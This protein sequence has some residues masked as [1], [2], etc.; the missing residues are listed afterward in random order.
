MAPPR[1]R[2]TNDRSTGVVVIWF[3]WCT[4]PVVCWGREG[5]TLA[6]AVEA[7]ASTAMPTKKKAAQGETSAARRDGARQGDCQRSKQESPADFRRTIHRQEPWSTV[8]ATVR[9]HLVLSGR[10]TREEDTGR[11]APRRRRPSKGARNEK[12]MRRLELAVKLHGTL[13]R[14]WRK[15][16]TCERSDLWAVYHRQGGDGREVTKVERDDTPKRWE[17]LK[18]QV[19]PSLYWSHQH[20][21]V[22]WPSLHHKFCLLQCTGCVSRSSSTHKP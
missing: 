19:L 2:M 20:V 10:N 16:E 4:K 18:I 17:W 1:A 5:E 21:Q 9:D 3:V 14:W 12:T 22:V 15:I 7:S 8:P 13:E 6:Y 11:G